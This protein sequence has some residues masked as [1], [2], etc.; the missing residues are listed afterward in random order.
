MSD[1]TTKFVSYFRIST[2]K[3]GGLASNGIESQKQ[4]VA[5]YLSSLEC[6]LVGTFE[7]VESGANNGRPQLAAAIQLAKTKK[8]ILVIAKLDRLSRNA[9]FLLQLQDG[10]VDFVACDMPNADKFSVGI[11]ALL[12][13]KERELISQR[14]KAGLEV[15]KQRGRVLGNPH[16]EVALKAAREAIQARKKVFVT[17][18]IKAIEEIQYTGITTLA[19]IAD[20]MNKRG[21]KTAR[22][23]KWT[24]TAVNR[25]LRA[26]SKQPMD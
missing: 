21:E 10:G 13:Q 12:A 17:T 25:V 23:G 14:T 19:K 11:L 7:E 3:S 4:S 9:A 16:G 24:A 8:A 26:K 1:M 6:D 18:A 5:R 22:G 20:C 2:D 15:A